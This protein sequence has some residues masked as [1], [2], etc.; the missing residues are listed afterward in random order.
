MTV[1]SEILRFVDTIHRDRQ[2]DKD[3]IFRGIELALLS[4]A[5]KKFGLI[6]EIDVTI[7]RESGDIRA[8]VEGEE[9]APEELGRIA[10]LSGKQVLYQ[11][12]REAERD[13]L[14]Q[15]YLPKVGHLLNGTIQEKK[16]GGAL[17]LSLGKAEGFLPRFEQSPAESFNT[18]DRIKVVLKDVVQQP[19]RVQLLCSRADPD[20]VRRL[21]ELEIPE[22]ADY[23]VDIKAIAREPGHRTKIAVATYDQNVDCVGACVGVKGARIR[24]IVDEL[25]GEKIDIV[26]WNE[27]IEILIVEALR[28]AEIAS[29]ELDFDTKS[30]TVYVKPDQQSLAIGRRGQNVRLASKLTGWDLDITAVSDEDLERMKAEGLE[31]LAQGL[32]AEK[33]IHED[34]S[35]EVSVPDA[36]RLDSLFQTAEAQEAAASATANEGRPQAEDRLSAAI[37]S[38]REQEEASAS[39][40]LDSALAGAGVDIRS[41]D[42][43]SSGTRLEDAPGL[44]E[45][46][47]ERLQRAGY[48]TVAAVKLLGEERLAR[49]EGIGPETARRI[50]GLLESVDG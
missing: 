23:V 39:R 32:F 37:R 13:V 3:V 17:I 49:L 44:D 25:F 38:H 29:L 47:V 43:A 19:N 35:I 30:A 28:P 15:E 10:A 7:D 40:T 5:Q 48:S 20:L 8:T 1:N 27:S 22:V 16:A 14:Y 9:L 45:A 4:A 42:S 33:K 34:G 36:S 18:G 11:K 12:I 50:L 24:N 26:R 31:S 46:L 6:D 21:F 2:I 41:G